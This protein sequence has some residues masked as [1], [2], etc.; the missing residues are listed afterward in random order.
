MF[1]ITVKAEQDHVYWAADSGG[2]LFL[3][4]TLVKV[5]QNE[6]YPYSML[7]EKSGKWFEI[8]KNQL[9]ELP[10]SW[11]IP[12]NATALLGKETLEEGKWIYIKPKK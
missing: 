7:I 8:V 12:I 5:Y 10:K 2:V 4:K 9:K 1:T 3:Y 11:A 6:N